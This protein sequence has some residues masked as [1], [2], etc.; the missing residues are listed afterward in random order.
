MVAVTDTAR[1]YELAPKGTR[2]E[3]LATGFTFTEG[4]VWNHA[5][6]F[7]LFSDMP[8]DVRRRW[9]EA[10]GVREVARPSNKGNG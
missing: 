5:G 9:D 10:G 2:I 8:G 4:P 1:F 6:K 7:L 3:R